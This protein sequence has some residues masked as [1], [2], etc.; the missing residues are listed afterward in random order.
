[1]SQSD[2]TSETLSHLFP[3]TA[4]VLSLFVIIFLMLSVT[5]VRSVIAALPVRVVLK[6]L[7]GLLGDNDPACP[8][9]TYK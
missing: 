5:G 4:I 2:S 1:M 7:G 9:G 8:Q 3:S 6:S